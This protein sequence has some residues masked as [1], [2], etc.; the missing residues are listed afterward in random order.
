MDIPWCILALQFGD[1]LRWFITQIWSLPLKYKV[2]V[3][4]EGPALFQTPEKQDSFM[5]GAAS[6]PFSEDNVILKY[7]GCVHAALVYHAKGQF[8]NQKFDRHHM[9]P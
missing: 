7:G 4:G 5:H 2:R 3:H 9:I 8:W 1:R 6:L